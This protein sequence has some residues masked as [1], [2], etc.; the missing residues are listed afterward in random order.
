MD[1][2]VWKTVS[3]L[4]SSM[5]RA[6]E[7]L[8]ALERVVESRKGESADRSYTSRLLAGGAAKIGGKVTEEAGELVQAAAAESD[9]RVVS[10]AADLVYH[11]LVLLAFR[12]VPLARVEDE[13]ARR[14]G[15]SG[16]D[17]KAARTVGQAADGGKT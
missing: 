17:E 9:E 6:G 11:M 16:L 5:R 1:S 7:V 12:G 4:Q 2:Q 10:E 8:E 14:F 13:L 3:D 15:V